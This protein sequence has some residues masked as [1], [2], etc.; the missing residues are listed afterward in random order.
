TDFVPPAEVNGRVGLVEGKQAGV[1]G[2][3]GGQVEHVQ[4]IK[5]ACLEGAGK[6]PVAFVPVRRQ[7]NRL[8]VAKNRWQRARFDHDREDHLSKYPS[9]D[10]LREAP[11]RIK[12]LRGEEDNDGLAAPE[13][14]VQG[15][16]PLDPGFDPVG[17]VEVQEERGVSLR[18]KPIAEFKY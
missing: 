12:P 15:L 1:G 7:V 16:L 18:V 6:A 8:G 13:V 2:S 10:H 14:L 3:V 11:L 4:V 5:P 17:F 9:E